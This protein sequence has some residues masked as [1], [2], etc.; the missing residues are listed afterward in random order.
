MIYYF[1]VPYTF[2]DVPLH[3]VYTFFLIIW[4]GQMENRVQVDALVKRQRRTLPV[5]S[6]HLVEMLICSDKSWPSSWRHPLASITLSIFRCQNYIRIFRFLRTQHK[7]RYLKFIY[8]MYLF[9]IF[10]Y[11]PGYFF[12]FWNYIVVRL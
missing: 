2:A 4:A 7:Y 10:I 11:F 5:F 3:S 12:I 6:W 8:L 1:I 9:C